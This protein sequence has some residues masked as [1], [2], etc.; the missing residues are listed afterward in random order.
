MSEYV[1]WSDHLT[2][3]PGYDPKA[4]AP[5]GKPIK[6]GGELPADHVIDISADVAAMKVG[7]VNDG[8]KSLGLDPAKGKGSQAANREA[9]IAALG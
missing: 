1:S 6:G 4:V 5:V 2:G 9:L 3:K 8:L 7:A